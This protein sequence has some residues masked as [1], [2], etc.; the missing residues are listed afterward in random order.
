MFR[1]GCSRPVRAEI[2]FSRSSPKLFSRFWVARM[3]SRSRMAG[4]VTTIRR[5]SAALVDIAPLFVVVGQL[6][7]MSAGRTL[8]EVLAGLRRGARRQLPGLLL[9]C[10]RRRRQRGAP[11]IDLLLMA[12]AVEGDAAVDHR[13]RNAGDIALQL[14]RG[15]AALLNQLGIQLQPQPERDDGVERGI[16]MLAGAESCGA[17]QSEVC[18]AFGSAMPR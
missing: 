3:S 10:P 8:L 18:N 14:I 17:D 2:L 12:T 5:R 16:G 13:D 11:F 7:S 6:A 15:V 9:K 4:T 1:P